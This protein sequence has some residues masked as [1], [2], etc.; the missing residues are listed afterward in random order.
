MSHFINIRCTLCKACVDIC[1][2]KSI[3]M[4]DRQYVIDSDTCEDCKVCVSVCP[5]KAIQEV[6]GTKHM[7]LAP[8]KPAATK[9]KAP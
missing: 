8:A 7:A 6:P 9:P 5:E 4:G 1:P 3:M 2:T